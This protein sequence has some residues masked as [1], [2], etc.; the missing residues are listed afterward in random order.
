[1]VL[2]YKTLQRLLDRARQRGSTE[3]TAETGCRHGIRPSRGRRSST[4]HDLDISTGSARQG[5]ECGTDILERFLTPD[6]HPQVEPPCCD[7]TDGVAKHLVRVAEGTDDL[8]LRNDDVEER[9]G[10]FGRS[11]THEADGGALTYSPDGCRRRRR[12]TYRVYGD[13]EVT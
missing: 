8:A 2:E 1:M 5:L 4:D 9:Y 13:V 6:E 12:D 7:V 3:D 10:N 11:E